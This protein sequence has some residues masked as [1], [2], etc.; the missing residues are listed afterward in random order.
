M[1]GVD[2]EVWDGPHKEAI[3]VLSNELSVVVYDLFYCSEISYVHLPLMDSEVVRLDISVDMASIVH[4]SERFQHFRGDICHDFVNIFALVNSLINM[5]LQGLLEVLNYEVPS[6]VL[7]SV[8]IV[9]G[10]ASVLSFF[11]LLV[12]FLEEKA[13]LEHTGIAYIVG[14]ELDSAH[15]LRI[16]LGKQADGP[17]AT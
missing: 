2:R 10:E 12:V 13:L 14:V 15:F 4:L 7:F 6:P 17:L 3:F 9:F 11:V 8:I 16:H 5:L 1:L